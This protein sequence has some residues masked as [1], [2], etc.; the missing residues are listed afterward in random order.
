MKGGKIRR[1]KEG[2]LI[3][4]IILLI[5]GAFYALIPHSVHIASGIGFGLSHLYHVIIG[6]VLLVIGLLVL[7][8]GRK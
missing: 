5:I 2:K 1:M 7:L 4:G 6:I 8:M 3:L